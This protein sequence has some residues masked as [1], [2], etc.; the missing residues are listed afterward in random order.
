MSCLFLV[1]V[2]Y[3]TSLI[4]RYHHNTKSEAFDLAKRHY[5]VTFRE[6]YP[7]AHMY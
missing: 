2:I 4:L 5:F 7:G 1:S 6:R 3:V